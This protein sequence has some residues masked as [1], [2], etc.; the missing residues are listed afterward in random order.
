M[1]PGNLGGRIKQLRKERNMTLEQLADATGSA[2]SYIWELE[3]RETQNPSA[4]KL[5]KIAKALGVT[6]DY[7]LEGDVEQQAAAEDKAFFRQYTDL[8][9]ETR[10]TI[11][12]MAKLLGKSDE[13]K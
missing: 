7:L 2:K 9:I 4:D 12:E 5:S 11:R 3:N 1:S 6:S 13:Q 8:P 10:K